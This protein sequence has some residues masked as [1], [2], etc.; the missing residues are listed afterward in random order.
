MQTS[1]LL[2]TVPRVGRSDERFPDEFQLQLSQLMEREFFIFPLDPTRPGWRDFSPFGS[3]SSPQ[4]ALPTETK[5][6]SG[7]S[8][9]KSGTSVNFSNSGDHLLVR[10]HHIDLMSWLAGFAPWEF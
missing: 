9:R 2:L 4:R 8:Q 1:E 7:T 3:L 6:E 5:V 10:V